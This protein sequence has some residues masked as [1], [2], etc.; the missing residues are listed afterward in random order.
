MR[1]SFLDLEQLF[2]SHAVQHDRHRQWPAVLWASDI[3]SIGALPSADA[4]MEIGNRDEP[5]AIF[6][7]KAYRWSTGLN[8]AVRSLCELARRANLPF[9]VVVYSPDTWDHILYRVIADG[10]GNYEVDFENPERLTE[11]EFVAKLLSLRGLSMPDDW[12]PPPIVHVPTTVERFD[13][14]LD[15]IEDEA[16]LPGS[17]LDKATL[18][19]VRNAVIKELSR[20]Q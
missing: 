13:A 15:A 14:V 19:Y 2:Y 17:S 3:D 12:E 1:T 6:E 9:W 4:L 10:K 5:L 16:M 18:I 7:F 11:R 20:A 8:T